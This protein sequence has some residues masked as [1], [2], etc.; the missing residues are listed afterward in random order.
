MAQGVKGWET[1]Y[2]EEVFLEF[3]NWLDGDGLQKKGRMR[4]KMMKKITE[5]MKSRMSEDE[6]EEYPEDSPQT[7]S[8]S[9]E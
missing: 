3:T 4:G 7:S 1:Q 9:R 2:W 5:L 8:S 6:V